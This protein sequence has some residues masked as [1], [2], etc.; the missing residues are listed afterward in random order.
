MSS[1][2]LGPG[3]RVGRYEIVAALGAGGMG[4]VYRARD[5]S[6]DRDVAIKVLPH[7]TADHPDA[8]E[9][10]AREAKSL[11]RL[12]HPH[13]CAV[14]DVGEDAGS[15]YLVM[16]LL[17]GETLAARIAR[18]PL[19]LTD[20]LRVGRE[21]AEALGGAHRQGVV[22][23][24]LKPGNVM[25]TPGGVKLLDFGLAKAVAP[26]DPE[27]APTLGRSLTVE[28]TV[29]GTLQ[30]MSPEQM[31]GKAA[32][33]RSDI[34]ALGA[35]L[36]EMA[37]GQRA[38]GGDSAS[39]IAAAILTV[40][41]PPLHASAALDR[42][43]RACL[44]KDPDRRWQSAQDVALQ[45]SMSGDGVM[46]AVSAA[47]RRIPAWV[48]WV[49]A[50]M[51]TAV[52][53][54]ALTLRPARPAGAAPRPVAFT[55]PAPPGLS[56]FLSVERTPFAVSPDSTVLAFIAGSPE[57][58]PPQIWL[59]PFASV[60]AR[61]LAGTEGAQ[62]LFWS[63]DGGSIGFVVAGKLRQ[64]AI[65]GG[66]PVTICDVREGIGMTGSWGADGQIIFAS[67]EGEAI[68]RVSTSGGTPTVDLKPD[69]SQ[70]EARFAWP[71]FLPDGR[72]YLYSVTGREERAEVRLAEPGR[73]PRTVLKARSNAR[74]VDPGFLLFVEDGALLARRFD[75]ASGTLTGDAIP[76][77][78]E[79]NYFRA[80]A[81]AHFT[82]SS[83]GVLAYSS[84]SDLSRLAWFDRAG[85]ETGQ[86]GPPDSYQNVRI[87]SDGREVLFDRI[88]RRTRN[89]D[90]WSLDLSRG[91]ETRLTSSPETEVA[92]QFGP[93][94]HGDLLGVARVRATA[95]AARARDRC[96][97]AARPRRAGAA[98]AV[99]C[100]RGS[101]VAALRRARR[102]R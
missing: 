6:L 50:A 101:E 1:M 4:E 2:R 54:A 59:R 99:G 60:A 71:A 41:P 90:L 46:A 17:E 16:E 102:P 67:V 76:V 70:G 52:A 32:D 10:L 43:V 88:T 40:D 30:Y 94:G 53:I 55:V 37:T 3:T 48:P 20:T 98:V 58:G 61:P 28:G 5:S 33:A 12:S 19:G 14:H 42:I 69:P 39:A 51:A 11:S 81:L 21:I 82:A 57:T 44:V 45:L 65:A 64:V 85:R 95:D 62:S 92:P 68:Y 31:E 91:F 15:L 23:R 79:V 100:F 13:I 89:Y 73:P 72:R 77:A 25:L 18:G 96:G 36:Y 63:P 56:F 66:A 38:F 9:R 29:V 83:S 35:V 24:D 80:T 86:L 47:P 74:Y 49:A 22:H 27:S 84:G 7:G 75:A 34:F 8:R 78:D 26:T 87:S 93:R 97:S